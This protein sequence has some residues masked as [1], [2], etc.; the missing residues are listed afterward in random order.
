[1]TTPIRI[2]IADD[3]PIVREG[4]HALISTEPNMKIVGEAASGEE[5]VQRVREL[6][7]DVILMDL[8]MGQMDGIEAIE[9]IK[10]ENPNARI[11]ALTSFTED[12]IVFPAIKA[13]ALGYL[14]KDSAPQELLQAIVNVYQGVPSLAPSIA[15]KLFQELHHP[16]QTTAAAANSANETL[17]EREVLILKH[18]AQGLTNQEIASLLVIS[19]R[20]V[21][22]HVGSI[23]SKLHLANRT[24]AALYALREGIARLDEAPKTPGTEL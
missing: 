18:V 20:T 8:I 22:N 7:P 9:R 24:Q 16:P 5:A 12:D 21:R 3:H 23:L 2:F 13:G 6:K 1:M 4:L 15:L 11:L 10:L 19:E 14:L 17:T